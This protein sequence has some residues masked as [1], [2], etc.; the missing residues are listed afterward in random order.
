MVLRLIILF[1]VFLLIAEINPW[2]EQYRIPTCSWAFVLFPIVSKMSEDFLFWRQSLFSL[3]GFSCSCRCHCLLLLAFIVLALMD[4][5][6]YHCGLN[7]FSLLNKDEGI[8]DIFIGHAY[9]LCEMCPNILLILKF[10]VLVFL[11][12]RYNTVLFWYWRFSSFVKLQMFS[13]RWFAFLF[14]QS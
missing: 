10:R 2:C 3:A 4:V 11:L 6:W 13:L 14:N 8:F 1:Y 7:Y 12:L 9:I 5:W